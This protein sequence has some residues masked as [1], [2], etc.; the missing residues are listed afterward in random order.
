MWQGSLKFR[1]NFAGLLSFISFH[2]CFLQSLKLVFSIQRAI[3]AM[4]LLSL[5]LDMGSGKSSRI[6]I[7]EGA[8]KYFF[9]SIACL[10]E[11]IE[12]V[13]ARHHNSEQRAATQS[14]LGKT[15]H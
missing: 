6:S 15:E 9:S 5:V 10:G 12:M 13:Q 8:K 1:R 4:L 11:L 2:C 14:M 7:R 3:K